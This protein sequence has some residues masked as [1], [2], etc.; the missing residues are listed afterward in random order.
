MSEPRKYTV[1][2]LYPRFDTVTARSA[3]DATK[4]VKNS[5]RAGAKVLGVFP[6]DGPVPD[7]FPWLQPVEKPE[8]P[9]AA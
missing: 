4:I 1:V 3:D 7:E 2:Y 9:E 6:A 8:G 5:F